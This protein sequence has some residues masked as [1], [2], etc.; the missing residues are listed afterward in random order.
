[1]YGSGGRAQGHK[2]PPWDNPTRNSVLRRRA[3]PKTRAGSAFGRGVYS[4]IGIRKGRATR[5]RPDL[6]RV[7]RERAGQP[8]AQVPDLLQVD[9]RELL[10]PCLRS[11][12]L[13]QE[14]LGQLLFR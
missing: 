9:L 8:P 13:L 5:D 1:T 4:T 3:R 12:L 2:P 11:P 14:V 7:Q 6:F 10:H